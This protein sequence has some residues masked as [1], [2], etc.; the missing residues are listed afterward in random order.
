MLFFYVILETS[1]DWI[2]ELSYKPLSVLPLE[3]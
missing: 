2:D 1:N 3:R